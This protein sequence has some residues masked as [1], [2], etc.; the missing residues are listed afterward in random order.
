VSRRAT[1]DDALRAQQVVSAWI[2]NLFATKT[3]P[4]GLPE[5]IALRALEGYSGT[6]LSWSEIRNKAIDF[7]NYVSAQVSDC[8]IRH[9]F[10]R[11]LGKKLP[12][13]SVSI[14]R[15]MANP[16]RHSETLF[17]AIVHTFT[18][19]PS[20]AW[21][22]TTVD[23]LC[24]TDHLHQRLVQ[25]AAGNLRSLAQAQDDLSILWPTLVQ[26]HQRRRVQGRLG[27]VGHF[28]SPMDDGL[29]FGDLQRND[30]DGIADVAVAAPT[31]VDFRNGAT[32]EQ[33]LL[34][35]HSNDHERLMVIVRTYVGKKD[36][37]DTQRQLKTR[38]DAYI[39][40]HRVIIDSF[41]LRA[42]LAFDA[43]PYGRAHY[44]LYISPSPTISAL[45]DA[46]E[47][48]DEITSSRDWSDEI[49]RSLE[50]RARK[51][52]QASVNLK[53]R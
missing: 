49:S 5:D 53:R 50:N 39:R 18:F 23:P 11:P 40:R 48:L 47:E 38:L 27:G 15:L 1:T 41:M 26:L 52:K 33:K 34:D 2:N 14:F 43:L 4:H 17:G 19:W 13:T 32:F 25:R 16:L 8:T 6:D 3:T 29:I 44:K 9:A 21:I 35:F 37:K 30:F 12:A 42:R 7:R 20:R 46:M 51:H 45:K 24:T 22:L 10:Q 36:L 31:L 28:V